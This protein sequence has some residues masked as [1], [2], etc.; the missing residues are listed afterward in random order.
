MILPVVSQLIAVFLF[1]SGN[2][3]DFNYNV[4]ISLKAVSLFLHFIHQTLQFYSCLYSEAF[5]EGILDF[6]FY[7]TINQKKNIFSMFLEYNVV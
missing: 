6:S 7:H 3:N 1:E 2:Y 4:Y 5:T